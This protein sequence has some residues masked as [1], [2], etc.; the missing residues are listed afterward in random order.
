MEI[1]KTKGLEHSNLKGF[2]QFRTEYPDQTVVDDFHIVRK[3][4]SQEDCEGNCYDWYEIDRHSRY[5]DKW[6]PAKEEI[7]TGI[8]D[9]QDAICILSEDVEIRLAE[10]EDALCEMS[11]E[12]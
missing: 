5:T 4:D 6:T 12:E 8:A 1:L 7:E 9:S 11:K 10:I 2:L 3:Y